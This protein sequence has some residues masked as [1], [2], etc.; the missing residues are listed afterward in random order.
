MKKRALVTGAT[1]AAGSF[2]CEFLRAQHPEVEVHGTLHDPHFAFHKVEGVQYRAVELVS[3][4]AV[5]YAVEQVKPD[6]VANFASWAR[7]RES[8]DRPRAYLENNIQATLNLLEACRQYA[9][10]ARFLHCSTSEVYGNV[11]KGAYPGGIPESAPLCPVNPYAASKTAQEVIALS[12]FRSF[13]L[14]VVVTRAFGY[15][16]SRRKDIAG[17]RFAVQIA[18]VER[19]LQTELV[20]GNLESVRTFLDV[21]DVCTAYWLALTNGLPGTV[22]NVGS[23]VPVSIGELLGRL[24]SRASRVIPTRLDPALLRPVDVVDQVPAVERIRALGWMP[25]VELNESLDR[26]LTEARRVAQHS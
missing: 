17:T 2:F 25:K 13:S 24:V 16:N 11:P 3:L 26:L 22:L 20:H 15:Q 14:P 5:D 6:M 12:Y 23:T 21:E 18:R 1:G 8:F 7:V 4:V 19:G 10:H 9:P